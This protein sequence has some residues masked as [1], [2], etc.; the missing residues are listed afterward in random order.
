MQASKPKEPSPCDVL[1]DAEL[2]AL[3]ERAI[4]RAFAKNT[5]IV[6]EGDRADSLYIVL[7]GR[8]RAYV[9]DDQGKEMFLSEAGKGEYFGEMALDEGPRSASVIT[10]EP[11]R[12]LVVPKDDFAAF[13]AKSPEFALHLVRKLIRRVRALTHDVKSLALMDV[14]GRVARML[15]DLA[16]E[17]DGA[18]VIED[19][20]TQQEMANRV[21]AS[22]EMISRILTELAAGGYIEVARDR[23]TISRTL[24]CGW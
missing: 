10:L 15:L 19:R 22:R 24:P 17:R 8:V 7:S 1:S 6:S 23:I 20:P 21:G 2:K 13:L 3:S 18:L 11:T 5:V 16:V 9:S 12:L 14:Y 4:M